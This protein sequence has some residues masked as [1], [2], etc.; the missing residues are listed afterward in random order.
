MLLHIASTELGKIVLTLKH[1][2]D[3]IRKSR[4]VSWNLLLKIWK[5]YMIAIEI[6][7]LGKN[8]SIYFNYMQI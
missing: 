4:F 8:E 2:Y 6:L 3:F 7:S 5:F 1:K